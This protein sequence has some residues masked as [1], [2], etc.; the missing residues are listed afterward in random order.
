MTRFEPLPVFL[1]T[2]PCRL[3]VVV[4]VVVVVGWR[5]GWG[6]WQVVDRHLVVTDQQSHV[7]GPGLMTPVVESKKTLC[8]HPNW[9]SNIPD[10]EV[11]LYIIDMC[12]KIDRKMYIIIK[13]ILLSGVCY[14]TDI[15]KSRDL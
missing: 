4:V 6:E 2:Y 7:T 14:L 1:T 5:G 13:R 12:Q 15:E 10:R 3:M 9:P 8:R 11:G